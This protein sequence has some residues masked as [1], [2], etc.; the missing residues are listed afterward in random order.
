MTSTTHYKITFDALTYT[1]TPYT[2]NITADQTTF[3]EIKNALETILNNLTDPIHVENI[4]C[5]IKSNPVTENIELF[6]GSEEPWTFK[7]TPAQ[8]E[9]L[10]HILEEV[11]NA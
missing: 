5:T 2:E 7:L 6:Q 8:A 11:S 3:I 1:E 4:Y 10:L 9:Y